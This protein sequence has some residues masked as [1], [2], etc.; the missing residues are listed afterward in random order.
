MCTH[1]NFQRQLDGYFALA[2][3]LFIH[4]FRRLS[5]HDAPSVF[6]KRCATGP[7][8]FLK[9]V[10]PGFRYRAH[11]DPHPIV[12]TRSAPFRCSWLCF[13]SSQVLAHSD[14]RPFKPASCRSFFRATSIHDHHLLVLRRSIRPF[15]LRFLRS[16]Q[17]RAHKS[18]CA[19]DVRA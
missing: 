16:T 11:F 19:P 15:P 4:D 2:L 14:A 8:G 12:K 7:S 18:V 6:A 13:T 9:P 1:R 5:C 3:A 17:R 10:Q